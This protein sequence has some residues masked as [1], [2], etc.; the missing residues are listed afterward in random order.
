MS[1]G[2]DEKPVGPNGHGAIIEGPVVLT[3]DKLARL[4]AI[5]KLDHVFV[6]RFNKLRAE[7]V[8]K[9]KTKAPPKTEDEKLRKKAEVDLVKW[10]PGRLLINES[11][12]P[13]AKVPSDAISDVLK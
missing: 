12:L 8:E 13:A 6:E 2:G 3:P 10:P 4:E 7:K 1:E 11:P 9:L 5:K